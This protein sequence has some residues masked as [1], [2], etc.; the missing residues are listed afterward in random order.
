MLRSLCPLLLAPLLAVAAPVPKQTEKE[1]VEAKFG[2]IVDPKGDSKFELDG[3]ALK[4][5]LPAGEERRFGYTEGKNGRADKKFDHTPKVEVSRTDDFVLTVRVTSPVA[6]S[7][8]G[9]G[10]SK[11][12]YSGGGIMVTPSKGDAYR[13]G[14][15]RSGN[16]EREENTFPLESPGTWTQGFAGVSHKSLTGD[17]NWLRMKRTGKD[18]N[19]E[20]SAD[21][22]DWVQLNLYTG[23]IRDETVTVALYAQHGSDKAHTVMFDEF[24]I[25]QP[26]GEKK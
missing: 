19:C 14:V 16:P 10:G 11:Y 9:I 18:L 20:A 8:D 26:K 7:A 15:L 23:A 3:D 21:G 5:T 1:K 6:A 4:I 22:K 24:K 13:F 17:T 12:G 2:K 25:E